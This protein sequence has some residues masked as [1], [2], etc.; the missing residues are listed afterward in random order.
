MVATIGFG[1]GIDDPETNLAIHW[2]GAWSTMNLYQESART[3]RMGQQSIHLV[4]TC[5]QFLAQAK[6]FAGEN[7]LKVETYILYKYCRPQLLCKELDG[8]PCEP[9]TGSKFLPCDNCQLLRGN[10]DV[11][12]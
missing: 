4:L 2:G 8:T 5:E 12:L 9:C 11:H 1:T 7:F 10:V 6:K 3:G